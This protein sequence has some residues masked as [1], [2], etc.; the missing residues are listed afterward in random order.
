MSIGY[1][2]LHIGR[3]NTKFSSL[4]VKNFTREKFISIVENNLN[5]LEQIVK[6][7]AENNIK[8]FRISSD[9]IPLA[10]HPVNEIPWWD[11][12]EERLNS[13]GQLIKSSNLRVS[14]HP[15]QYTVINST[16]QKVIDNSIKDLEYHCKF[17]DLLKV[18]STS[19]MVLHIGGVYGD[20]ESAINRFINTFNGLDEC[21]KNRLVIENDDK[22][23]NIEDVLYVSS[24]INIP[25]IFDN[26]HHKL[27]P[28][29]DNKLNQFDLIKRV[30]NTW[31]ECDGNQKIHYS[32]T[33]TNYKNGAH[34]QFINGEEFLAFYDNLIDKDIDIMLEVK[35]KNLSAVKCNIITKKSTNPKFVETE[36]AKYK[37]FVLDKSAA[38]YN[39]IRQL[40]KEKD[41]INIV[42]FYRLIDKATEIEESKKAQVNTLQHIW[43]YFT[44]RATDKEKERF[45]KLIDGFISN[46]K[47]IT[48]SKNYLFKL[49]QKYNVDYLLNSLYFYA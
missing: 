36:W 44:K 20:K 43:G 33:G 10:S 30:S 22:S 5:S 37:Y 17:L 4:I 16:S 38:I 15:G 24:K 31:K 25:V 35:D 1:A 23:Y 3:E 13:L 49:A 39:E 18:D 47:T 7:N 6:Y 34:S 27:N 12:F 32:Q 8:L 28:P 29:K 2:C 14:M 46:N 11:I 19:K 45:L 42:E 21:I 26:L 41:N 9:I 48:S 40:L